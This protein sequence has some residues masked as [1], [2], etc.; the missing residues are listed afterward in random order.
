MVITNG[1]VGYLAL[2][3]VLGSCLIV[4]PA[5]AQNSRESAEMA[6]VNQRFFQAVH[7]PPFDMPHPGRCDGMQDGPEI[8]QAASQAVR[9]QKVDLDAVH[10]RACQFGYADIPGSCD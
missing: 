1:R 8:W 5:H 10:R 7:C 2:S 9:Q 6:L 3:L 4:A